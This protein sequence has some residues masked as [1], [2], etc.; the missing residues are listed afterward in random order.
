MIESPGLFFE[1]PE[2]TDPFA[3]LV[4]LLQP[5]LPFSKLA[6][7]SGPW[8]VEGPATARPLFCVIL[9]GGARLSLSGEPPIDL[10][11][12]DF[13]LIPA[14]C[15]FAMSSIDAV[16]N[17]NP[18]HFAV[19]KRDDETRHGDPDGP[20]NI[21]MLVGGLE[22][23]SPDASLLVSLLPRLVHIR[24]EKQFATIVQLIRNEAREDKPARAMILS[25]L[26][27]VLLI[28][29]LRSVSGAAASTGLLRGLSD[30]R[31]AAA[32]RRMHADPRHDWTVEKLAGEAALSRSVFFERF[33]KAMGV[34]PME[35]L[36][37]WRMALAKNLLRRGET[38]IK[39]IADRIGYGSASSFSV[40]FARFVGVPPT[41]Y[42][43]AEASGDKQQA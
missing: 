23:G 35:Y 11:A 15:D 25:R 38:G 28:E 39:E 36:L 1:S 12:D 17:N 19:S 30:E 7:G 10:Q 26:L 18:A 13:V 6:S 3:D 27:E 33:R 34:A 40:A 41:H 14:A 24:G 5:S 21:R 16:D 29:A 32:L 9:D 8:R 20:A 37:S 22:F 2:L 31:L 4:A 43:R 42:A